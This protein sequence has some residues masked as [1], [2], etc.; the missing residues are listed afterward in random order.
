MPEYP[1]AKGHSK[2]PIIGLEDQE[3]SMTNL[4]YA[5]E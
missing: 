2:R 4:S 3:K 5:W 1:V